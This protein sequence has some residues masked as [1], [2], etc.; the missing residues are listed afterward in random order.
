MT[1]DLELINLEYFLLEGAER[2]LQQKIFQVLLNLR[3]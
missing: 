3:S 1:K 2:A